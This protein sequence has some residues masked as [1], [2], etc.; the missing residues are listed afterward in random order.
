MADLSSSKKGIS[1]TGKAASLSQTPSAIIQN[2]PS[3]IVLVWNGSRWD[4][5]ELDGSVI[6]DL[7]MIMGEIV[8]ELCDRC[9]DHKGDEIMTEVNEQAPHVDNCS[10]RSS[11]VSACVHNI[12]DAARL[13][14]S[15]ASR[16]HAIDDKRCCDLCVKFLRARFVKNANGTDMNLQKQALCDGINCL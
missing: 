15:L 12:Q 3:P 10:I 6:G 11:S 7:V 14:S 4:G 13:I 8:I 2:H 5:N 9:K 1:Q 16:Y